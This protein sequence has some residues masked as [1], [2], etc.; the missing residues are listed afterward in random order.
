MY[1]PASFALSDVAALHGLIRAHPLG[2]LVVP[3]ADGLEAN[4]LPFVLDPEPAPFGTLR[5]HVARGNAVWRAVPADG[6]SLV[7]F[8]GPERYISPSWYPS[9]HESEGRV[10]PTWNYVVAHAYGRLRAVDDAEWL[11][12]HLRELVEINEGHR[13][14]PWRMEDAP[15]DWLERL[16]GGVV[17]LELPIARL[18]GKAKLSQNRSAADRAGV[19]D[20]LA[21][22]GTPEALAMA[23]AVRR[24]MTD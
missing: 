6:E 19:V 20:G 18:L 3:T 23:D 13:A 22:E 5:G 14:E 15:A 2:A 17:G 12:R 11:H 21:R 16:A 24:A 8:Q 7:I 1:V 9:K 10:V 4:H